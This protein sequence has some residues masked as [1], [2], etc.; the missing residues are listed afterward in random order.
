MTI[1]NEIFT[2][3]KVKKQRLNILPVGILGVN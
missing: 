1:R 3:G 2:I